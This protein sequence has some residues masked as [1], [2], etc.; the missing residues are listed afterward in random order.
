MDLKSK[1]RAVENFPKEGI[2]FKDITTLL[3][4]G[5]AYDYVIDQCIE[6]TKD[7]EYDVI[8]G[9]EARGFLIAAPMSVKTKKGFIPVRKPGK[10]PAETVSYEYDLEYG[11]DVL[12]IHKDA[13]K[14]GTKVLI[15]DDL[16]AT[17]GTVKA[18]T[19]LIESLGGEVVGLVFLME[20]TE[21]KGRDLLGD[22][23]VKTI[24]EYDI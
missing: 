23:V 15:A 10:L 12:E 9:P 18:V 13:I 19:E 20:L 14:P 7:I 4:D 2:S 5:E 8:V 3:M 24:L 1:I 6:L 22:K 17:G 21:L 11:S 16:L